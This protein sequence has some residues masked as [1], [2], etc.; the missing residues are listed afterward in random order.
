MK[1]ECSAPEF[2]AYPSKRLTA[3]Q[4]SI[5]N[6]LVARISSVG[7]PPEGLREDD[8]LKELAGASYLYEE[9]NHLAQYDAEK[10]KI[11]KRTLRP[12]E[13]R[14]LC[15]KDVEAQLKHFRQFIERSEEEILASYP[16]GLGVEPYW[17][18]RLK[19]SLSNRE[20]LYSRLWKAG[21]LSFRRKRKA[22]IAF[23]VVKKKDGMQRLICDARQA[24][25]CHR[26]PPPT[27]LSTPAAF[28][29]LDLSDYNLM[30]QQGFGEIF[31]LHDGE[32]VQSQCPRV[33]CQGNEGDVGDCFYNFT[34]EELASWFCT[35]D[36]FSTERL[37]ELDMAPTS[38][39]D[40]DL[41][42]FTPVVPGET[43]IPCFRG[44]CMGWSWA[45]HLAQSIVSHQASLSVNGDSSDLVLDKAVVPDVTPARPVIGV[46]VDNLQV[47]G[48]SAASVNERMTG[49]VNT[50]QKLGI[51]FVLSNEEAVDKFE[52]LG[53][54]FDLKRRR[55]R[56]RAARSWRLYLATRALLRRGRI[57]GEL[58]R[59]WIGHVVHH[60]Q[61]TRCNMSAIH[62]CYRFVEASLGKRTLVWPSV[63]LEMRIVLGLIFLNEANLEAPYHPTV[64]LGDSSTYGFSLMET[65]ASQHEIKTAMKCHERWRFI[66]A[67]AEVPDGESIHRYTSPA[68]QAPG[69]GLASATA[70]G[71]S[72][73]VSSHTH[74]KKK[75]VK[76]KGDVRTSKTITVEVPTLCEPLQDCW[77]KPGRYRLLVARPWKYKQ[78]H[79]NLKEARVLLMGLR[80]HCRSAQNSHSRLL[81]LS[82]NLRGPWLPMSKRRK[83]LS[84]QTCQ[85][86]TELSTNA[87]K[88]LRPGNIVQSSLQ[89]AARQVPKPSSARSLSGT[90]PT[91]RSSG[92]KNK[93]LEQRRANYRKA[94]LDSL[95]WAPV[96]DRL[97]L[98]SVSPATLARY[99]DCIADFEDWARAKGKNTSTSNLDTVV[100]EF[101]FFGYEAGW[102]IWHGSYLVYGLQL[103]RNRGSDKDFLCNS[104]KCLKAWRRRVPAQARVP[105]PEEV[106]FA[107]A[108][109][110]LDQGHLLAFHALCLQFDTYMRPSEAL[111]L[112]QSQLLPPG[113]RGSTAH[114]TWG[115][116]LA[117]QEFGTTTK[118]GEVDCSIMVG[119]VCRHWMFQVMAF[120]RRGYQPN[121][122]SFV[123]PGL[124]LAKY[125]RLFS[126]ACSELNLP[127]T[128]TPHMVRHSAAS[129]DQCCKRRSI[130]QIQ[131][132]GRWQSQK[133]V[134][135]YEKE[136]YLLQAW[137]RIP[138][139]VQT[140]VLHKSKLF[141]KRLIETLKASSTS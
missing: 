77:H 94:Q 15:S 81:S 134:V 10:I 38:I 87:C 141:Q 5:I 61:L 127:V 90:K 93:A 46:Y 21:L 60:F 89:P 74:K 9:A 85:I 34:I 138:K 78:E 140:L 109:F 24:N 122:D 116:M 49:I 97:R 105:M 99:L 30:E 22:L 50:F 41:Q 69:V 53:L 111:N 1:A 12:L 114:K 14:S 86:S 47:I 4:V 58:L 117:P 3:V 88:K 92:S 82:D 136:A 36:S 31:G 120:C 42:K 135:R 101:L 110:F 113:P 80:R 40:D 26:P 52:T 7:L 37:Q 65:T 132:R 25:R 62:A 124:T 100:S 107:I 129:N 119:D 70:Y 137:D 66:E 75:K 96:Q 2:P 73:R 64:Y 27:K 104:K 103:V 19:K 63:R 8:A 54:V 83:L 98:K 6:D 11:F 33:A 28:G 128:V 108:S 133:S 115:V 118:T 79:I 123:F 16:G 91:S 48:G 102:H 71:E 18:P 57:P 44:V 121:V 72:I 67:P 23:F 126:Q 112:R 17:D 125:E 29:D 35:M 55:I 59:V 32:G 130:Q 139:P 84:N 68:G 43:L 131:K 95:S 13:A 39:F 56:H 106:I 51:P 76:L 45:L 20:D